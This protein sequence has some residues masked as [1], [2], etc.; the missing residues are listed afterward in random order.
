MIIV[1]ARSGQMCNQLM[2]LCAAYALGLR[3]KEDVKCPIVDEKLKEYF[4]FDSG[5]SP[6]RIE[7]YNTSWLYWTIRAVNCV[8]NRLRLRDFVFGRMYKYNPRKHGKSQFLMDA[9]W[10]KEDSAIIE[11]LAECQ[12]FFAFK[13]EIKAR[14]AAYIAEAHKGVE[15]LIAVHARRGD[16]R[17]FQGG[18]YY[19]P[20]EEL[21]KFMKNLSSDER[22]VRFV[23]FSNEKIDLAN[24]HNLGLDVIQSDGSAVDD[25][26]RMSLCDY[27]MGPPSTFAWWA[28]VMGHIPRLVLKKNCKICGLHDFKLFENCSYIRG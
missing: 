20:D 4:C 17:Q 13:P 27:V 28:M 2:T 14:N 23:L 19:F 21:A 24:Y 18:R 22:S 16:Y 12:R 25:L 7:L 8:L 9:M 15:K 5:P 1:L 6:I 10:H 3:Y 11:N 26:C